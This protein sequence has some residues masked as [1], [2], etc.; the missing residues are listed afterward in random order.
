MG[1]YPRFLQKSA[2]RVDSRGVARRQRVTKGVKSAQRQEK[3]R[4]SGEKTHEKQRSERLQHRDH[5]EHKAH[6]DGEGPASAGKMA[7]AGRLESEVHRT[8]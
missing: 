3:N 5:K 6:R 7:T 4:V 8:W 2:E 1:T